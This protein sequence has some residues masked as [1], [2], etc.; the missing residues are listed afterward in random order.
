M[1]CLACGTENRPDRRFCRQCGLPLAN[2]CGVCGASNEPGDR[3]CGNCGTTLSPAEVEPPTTAVERTTAATTERR[4]V[5]VLFVDLVG[6]TALAESRDP[7]EVQ[8]L[9][10]QYFDLARDVIG[11]YG[12]IV[13][14]FIGDAVM[15]VWGTPV[16]YEDDPERAVRAALDLVASVA[17]LDTGDA[18]LH[19][20]ARA[21]VMSGDA[22]VTLGATGQGMVSGDLVNTASRLQGAAA[23]GTVLVGDATRRASEAAISYESAG[24]TALKGKQEGVEAWRAIA[25]LAGRGGAGRADVLEPPFVGRDTEF[26]MLKELLHATGGERRARLISITGIAGIG[27]SRLAWELDK[28]I[29][30]I[31]EDIYWHQG[32][33][34]AYGEGVAFWAL[35]E[36]VRAR[37]GIAETDAPDVARERLEATIADFVPDADE[38]RWLGPRLAALLGL[39]EMP[40]T[41]RVDLFAAWRTFFERVSDRGTT[42]LVFEDLQWADQGLFDFIESLL[43]WSRAHPILIVTLARPEV[44]ERRPTWGAGQR[45]FAALHLEPLPDPTIRELLLGLAP[46]IPAA[47]VARIVAR[48]EGVPLYAVETVRMLV[49]S[50]EL[51]VGETGAYQMVGDPTT[52]QVPETLRGLIAARLDALEL[53][54]RSLVQDASVLG[55]SFTP[56]ALAAISSAQPAAVEAGLGRLVRREVLRLDVDP[57]SPERGQYAFV[58]GLL[59]E[60]A[61]GTLAR[62]ERRARHLAAV[63]YFEATGNEEIAAIVADHYLLAYRATTAGPEADALAAQARLALRAAGERAAALHSH[64]Q[65]LGFLER[66]LEVTV[67]PIERAQL[68]ERAGESARAGIAYGQGERHLAEAM[69]VYRATGDRSSLAR[70]AAALGRILHAQTSIE[71]ALT[72]LEATLPEVTD[73]GEDEG[74]ATFLAELGRAYMFTRRTEDGLKTVERGLEMAERLELIPVIADALITKGNLLVDTSRLREATALQRGAAALAQANGLPIIQLRALNNLMVRLYVEDPR[75]MWSVVLESLE[76]ARRV[77]DREWLLGSLEWAASF[78]IGPG[79][80]DEALAL[81]DEADRPDLPAVNRVNFSTTRMAIWAYR[82]DVD[83]AQALFDEI[84]PL[85]GQMQREEDAAFPYFDAATIAWCRGDFAAALSKSLEGIA[86]GQTVA[87]WGALNA[88]PAAIALGD[89]AAARN[90]VGIAEAAPD[91]GR[92]AAAMRRYLHGALTIMEGDVDGGVHDVLEAARYVR[93]CGARFDLALVLLALGLVA[94]A[95]HPAVLAAVAEARA[96]IDDLGARALGDLLDRVAPGVASGAGAAAT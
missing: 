22:A 61:Y 19:L 11:R 33:S 12:G 1:N 31:A 38:R 50:G 52:L 56:A 60:V 26:R 90:V 18:N 77:G 2:V 8:T 68:H 82:G 37:T 35:G 46:G 54:D 65:A 91:R 17:G 25:V 49:G 40:S 42:I 48:A 75:E 21:A 83:A 47:L 14:K 34:P 44:T 86:I 69:A 63:R 32:R 7:E 55:L 57:R 41:E 81:L 36:M 43:E 67:D 62:P 10:R 89:V 72:L 23:A 51:V 92:Y 24:T 20:Q 64:V 78:A 80:W 95:D 93:E 66:A 3:F 16:A 13:E 79:R 58:Q 85:R 5:S 74:L 53:A 9:Q 15:A 73:L 39:E 27:K 4:F 84:A 88:F 71:R 87:F 29:D 30:G 70:S 96:I 59:Q 28:Y 94:P 6:F 45:N 76:L